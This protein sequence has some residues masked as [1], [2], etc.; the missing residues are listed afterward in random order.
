LTPMLAS[1]LLLWTGATWSISLYLI[2]AAVVTIAATLAARET[3]RQ[4]LD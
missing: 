1:A 3:A 2:A 4:P